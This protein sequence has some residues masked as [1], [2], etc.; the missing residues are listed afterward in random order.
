MMNVCL[1]FL[2][3]RVSV[4][5]AAAAAPHKQPAQV[6]TRLKCPIDLD[7][8]ILSN[9]LSHPSFCARQVTGTPAADVL[10][11]CVGARGLPAVDGFLGGK[12]D[13][14]IKL[15]IEPVSTNL[16]GISYASSNKLKA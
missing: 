8:R 3:V 1:G 11:M 14:F 5:D 2:H 7:L 12:N 15:S 9:R 13:P 6:T 10:V 4:T 16:Q